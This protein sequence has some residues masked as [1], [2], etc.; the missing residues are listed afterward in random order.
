MRRG[1]VKFDT[2]HVG[3]H[4]L[5]ATTLNLSEKTQ[6]GRHPITTNEADRALLMNSSNRN[7]AFHSQHLQT[8]VT[9][10]V[11]E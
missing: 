5:K 7:T 10:H 8:N 11:S 2:V 6:N 4:T 1:L 9:F 3:L